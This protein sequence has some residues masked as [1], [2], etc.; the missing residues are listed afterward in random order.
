MVLGSAAWVWGEGGGAV[1]AVTAWHFLGRLD[2]LISMR[3]WFIWIG[4]FAGLLSPA[5]QAQTPAGTGIDRFA[6][7]SFAQ[8]VRV[9]V[10]LQAGFTCN[11]IQILRGTD[12]LDQRSVGLIGGLC[13]DEAAA[14]TYSYFDSLQPDGRR[15]YYS[16]LLGGRI[17]SETRSIQLFDFATSGFVMWPNPAADQL[18]LQFDNRLEQA[19]LLQ[20]ISLQG[21]SQL[22]VETKASSLQMN[23]L[24]LPAGLY[25]VRLQNLSTR[26]IWQQ[27]LVVR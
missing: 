11:G 18:Q 19:H 15:Y 3:L 2:V 7:Q 23:V 14:V 16:L 24:E 9:E 22:Q 17:P 20:I 12:S 10:T 4:I 25:L 5:V 1:A 26:Q 27:R 13:G 21:Q 6:L 8:G